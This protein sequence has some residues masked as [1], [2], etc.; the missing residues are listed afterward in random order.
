MFVCFFN[1][2]IVVNDSPSNSQNN[3]RA[4]FRFI[5]ECVYANYLMSQQIAQTQEVHLVLIYSF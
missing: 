1:Q 4:L 2:I 5:L 3:Y